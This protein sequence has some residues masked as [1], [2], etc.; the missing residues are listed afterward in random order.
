MSPSSKRPQGKRRILFARIGWMKRYDGSAPGDKRPIG[1]GSYNATHKGHELS[2]FHKHEGWVY[3]FI[4]PASRKKPRHLDIS[5]IAPRYDE[6]KLDNVLVVFVA[7]RFGK[8]RQVV[9][10]WYRDATVYR[11]E[12]TETLHGV[13]RMYFTRTRPSNAFLLK[14][15]KRDHRADQQG[16]GMGHANVSYVYSELGELRELPGLRGLLAF[17]DSIGSRQLLALCQDCH[18]VRNKRKSGA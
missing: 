18:A 14:E 3:G 11:D 1:G 2:N 5:R 16:T 8:G 10:G 7:R 12:R 4:Q 9:V 6:A 13:K 17:V 15:D